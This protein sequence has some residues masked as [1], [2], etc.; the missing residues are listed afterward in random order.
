MKWIFQAGMLFPFI[1]KRRLPVNRDGT[2]FD[3]GEWDLL[4]EVAPFYVEIW[5]FE[6]LGF[7]FPLWP[8]AV[9]KE[10]HPGADKEHPMNEPGTNSPNGGETGAG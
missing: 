9:I 6:W 2:P 5:A 10:A 3:S 8:W 1:G 7:G 4:D